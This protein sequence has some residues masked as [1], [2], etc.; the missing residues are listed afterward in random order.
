MLREQWSLAAKEKK[1]GTP[2][3]GGI[4]AVLLALVVATALLVV[5]GGCGSRRC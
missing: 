5:A 4:E 2:T 1:E 3:C